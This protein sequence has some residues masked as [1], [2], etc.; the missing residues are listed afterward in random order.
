MQRSMSTLTSTLM[1]S[2]E[3]TEVNRDTTVHDVLHE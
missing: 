2:D 1:N 3:K